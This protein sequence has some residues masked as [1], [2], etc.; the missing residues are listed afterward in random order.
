MQMAGIAVGSAA[1]GE[2]DEFKKANQLNALLVIQTAPLGELKTAL[3]QAAGDFD[4][5]FWDYVFEFGSRI[6]LDAML[7]LETQLAEEMPA[8]EAAQ[9]EAVSPEKSSGGPKPPGN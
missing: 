6:P 7:E 5:F 2:M 3:R 9:V 4:T 1:F 8:I